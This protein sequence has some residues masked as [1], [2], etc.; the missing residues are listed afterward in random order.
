MSPVSD[1]LHETN[2]ALLVVD[3]QNDFCAED[4]FVASIGL[5][6]A[7][8]RDIVPNLQALIDNARQ[9]SIPVLWALANYDDALVPSTFRRRKAVAGIQRGCCVPGTEGYEAFGVAPK[10]GEPSF[11]KHS[12]S[13]FTNPEFEKYLRDQKIETLVFAGV[14]TNV[15]VEATIREAFNRGFHVVVAEDCV[16][17]HTQPLHEATLQNVRALL[18]CVSPS[19]E[20]EEAWGTRA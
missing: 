17:S 10:D 4:G 6:P 14:Q 20:I 7:P 13:A 15:C 12:Y 9:Q 5:D 8:C 16:A 3:M 19:S 18:G 11:V 1:L 2:S